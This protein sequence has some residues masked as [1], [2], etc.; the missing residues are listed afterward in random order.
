MSAPTPALPELPAGADDGG[1]MLARRFGREVANYFAGSPLN[2]VSFLREDPAFLRRAFAHPRAAFL[3]LDD[4]APLARGPTALAYV[5]RDAVA[6]LTGPEPFGSAGTGTGTTGEGGSGSGSGL[7][8][9]DAEAVAKFRSDRQ[10]TVVLFLGLDERDAGGSARGGGEG[11]KGEGEG[12]GEGFAYRDYRGSPYFAVDVTPRGSVADAARGVIAAVTAEG[13]GMSFLPGGPRARIMTLNAPE[14]AIYAQSRA[15]LDWHARNPFC[16]GCGERTMA[17][18][19]GTKRLCP[20]TD[21]AGVPEGGEPRKR[22]DCPTR[23]GISNLCFPR[24]DPTVIM[25]V[26]SADGTRLLLGRSKRFPPKWLAGFLEPGESIEEAVRRETWEESGVRVG[27][28]VI[29]SS[30]PWPYPANLMIG[31]VGQALPP[32]SVDGGSDSETINLGNDP[33]LEDARWFPFDEVRRALAALDVDK[34]EDRFSGT[35]LAE[36]K[37]DL[38][39]PPQT[40]IANRLMDAV[41][42]GG[43]LG[44]AA[45]KM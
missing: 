11:G 28:V 21:L 24:T 22:A 23:K 31:A 33:E 3:L 18:S 34:A 4:L 41:V 32:G 7:G 35:E 8:G 25:A 38:G 43:Y 30:Q 42:N 5:G 29:H 10:Q 39:L 20:P 37:G 16:G 2:R 12:E 15:L 36:P 14:A 40:A 13:T 26:V 6:P 9:L 27:R 1:S 44:A 17:V 19:A 45:A